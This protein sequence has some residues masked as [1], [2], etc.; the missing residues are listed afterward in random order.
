MSTRKSKIFVFLAC[1]FFIVPGCFLGYVYYKV[2]SD[3]GTRI[4]RGV[5]E[6]IISSESPV[7]YDD[8]QTPIGA[9]FEE[10][11]R[12]YIH[13]E[14]IP[15]FFVKALIAAEDRDFFTHRGLDLKAILR[16]LLANVRAR[17][18]VQGGSTITQQTAKNIFKRE[19]RSYMAKLKELIQA[20]LL[21]RRYTKEEILEMYANQ[22][23]VTG[24][25]KGLNIAAQYF[26]GK[27]AE[28]L[29]LAEAAFIAG[30][31]KGPNRYNPFIKKSESERKKA[32][33]L[34]KIRK[35][36]VLSNMLKM[37]FITKA[38][39]L[40]AK[41]REVPFQQGTI[42]YRLNVIL[43]YIREQLE[44]D[45]F[46]A[47]LQDQ[48]VDNIATSG[49]GIYTS[50]NRDAQAAALKS[51]RDH[52]PLMDVR[53]NGY[54]RG[55]RAE[56]YREALDKGLKK[57][58]D[59]LPFLARIT[60]I[61]VEGENGHL[62]VAWENG[63]GI[64][65][66][67]GLKPIAQAWLQWKLGNWA[68]FDKKYL[69]GFLENFREGDLVSVQLTPSSQ[70]TAELKLN[71][72]TIPE[73]EGGVVVIHK[74]MIKAMAG[75][76]FD[77]F[78]NRAV[79]AKRQLGS[80]FKPIVYAAALQLNW[81]SLD[82]LQNTRDMFQFENTFYLPRPDHRP[83]SENVSLA[84]AGAKSENIATVW[85]LYHL[86]DHLNMSEFRQLTDLVG[87][88][89]NSGESYLEYK[90]RIRDYHGVVVNNEAL[91]EAAFE[92][93][94]KEVESDVIFAGYDEILN[95]LN[96]LHFTIDNEKFS[97]E[98]PEERQILRFNYKALC[99]LQ[100]RMSEDFQEISRLLEKYAQVPTPETRG[101][102]LKSLRHFYKTEGS[103]K[104]LK[105]IYTENPELLSSH[106]LVPLTPECL[107]NRPTP[108]LSR[109][110]WIDGLITSEILD[111]IQEHMKGHY[112]RL[113]S[114]KR[115]DLEVLSKVRD[116]RTLVSLSYVAYLSKKI[117][118][119]SNLDPVLAFP[120]G[121][122]SISITEAALA[123]QTIITGKVYPLVPEGGSTNVPI[124]TKI[125]DREGETLWEYEPKPEKVLSERVSVLVTEILRKVME[126]GTGRKAK[127]AVQVYL[128]HGE[129]EI[130]FPI[131]CF[132]KTGTA[133]RFTNSSFV[134][135]I[136]GA[137]DRT[138]QL[139]L[140]HGY[141]IA[142]YVGYDDNRPMKTK[143]MAIYG[144]SGAL[145]L[146]IDTA[147]AIVNR[148]DYKRN[149][150]PADLAFNPLADPSHRNLELQAVPVSPI[151]GLPSTISKGI[152]AF[153]PLP[154]VLA[155]VENRGGAW[156]FKRHFDPIKGEAE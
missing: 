118:I 125:V 37:N 58:R 136:P 30:S 145:P 73:L 128:R 88:G 28:K 69:P 153:S 44:S 124:I 130:G 98:T 24:F 27:E 77:R 105:A 67:E 154:S 60:H 84:W 49:I 19:R 68:V 122:N 1:V 8:R 121:P 104:A 109:E 100:L 29:D 144:S 92:Q 79:D 91:L 66:Y 18:V 53:L 75:G 113:L 2:T 93:S 20:F 76:F 17:K 127:D 40:D 103:G 6:Q 25:G 155:E 102:L 15:P 89:R 56:Q 110:I 31:V 9:F 134:G 131:P 5:I 36:Y 156:E 120:L 4:Q 152:P 83:Q 107:L 150:Q 72:S 61:D 32:R 116:F 63:G 142:T 149:L 46:R 85:L 39:Y 47:I 50:I 97:I 45:Y 141:V 126:L 42:T 148:D 38:Q 74:G 94:K 114:H 108:L 112:R 23:F 70:Q 59:S 71:L 13:Y 129:E 96:R 151:T 119:S 3:A 21:E 132:G 54:V 43:D 80:I 133:N 55:Q 140:Q 87:L 11:H 82:P 22:F 35:D 10:I 111:L 7:Y 48:G 64:I 62:V 137:H 14:N 106:T 147:N 51:L 99:D 12:K 57:S 33:L 52:L 143:H 78:F 90:E 16:S 138:G 115:Y 101:A 86:T 123:Y 81:N 41:E 135:F 117:G 26:F 95:N 146:W 34:A 65:G 139:D